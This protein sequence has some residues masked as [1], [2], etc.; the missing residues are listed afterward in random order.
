MVD[1]LR[2][3]GGL[4]CSKELKLDGGL[5]GECDKVV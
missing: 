2:V 1:L 3:C 5:G 4:A